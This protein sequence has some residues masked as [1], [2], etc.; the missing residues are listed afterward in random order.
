MI[1]KHGAKEISTLVLY[2]TLPA[3]IIRA[4]QFDFS[5]ELLGQSL[6]MIGMAIAVY[7]GK[8]SLSYLFAKL[9]RAKGKEKDV[10]QVDYM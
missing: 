5:I 2:I 6:K 9:L 1:T 7:A 4:M 3:L 10:F 8:I